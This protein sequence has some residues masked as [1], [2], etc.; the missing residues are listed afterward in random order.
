MV[1]FLTPIASN[2]EDNKWAKFGG[3]KPHA[4][5]TLR[6]FLPSKGSIGLTFVC[7]V[8][9]ENQNIL[10]PAFTL[11]FYE[12]FLSSLS[13]ALDT[14][15]IFSHMSRPS[16]TPHN[17]IIR[18]KKTRRQY[19]RVNA[20]PSASAQEKQINASLCWKTRGSPSSR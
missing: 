19:A 13:R 17:R 7:T 20:Q 14:C 2:S 4:R 6:R 10:K 11:L 12:R 8:P 3:S 18:R 15:A 1:T 9:T 5:I 16:Q